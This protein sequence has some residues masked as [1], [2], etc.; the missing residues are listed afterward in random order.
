[1]DT[2]LQLGCQE[3]CTDLWLWVGAIL[4]QLSI[5]LNT[6]VLQQDNCRC[7][8]HLQQLLALINMLTVVDK[9]GWL[10]REQANAWYIPC[11]GTYTRLI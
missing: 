10:K 4:S 5:M 1:M 6:G 8:L 9:T 2:S 7:L 11:R 3:F